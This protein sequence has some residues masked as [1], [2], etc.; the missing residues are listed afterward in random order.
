MLSLSQLSTFTTRRHPGPDV[1][2][3]GGGHARPATTSAAPAIASCLIGF[4][5]WLNLF[6][7]TLAAFNLPCQQWSHMAFFVGQASR[8]PLRGGR[9]TGS[10]QLNIPNRFEGVEQ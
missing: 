8:G 6:I 5:P 7:I 10:I 2:F 4:P 9:Q 3:A 1:A